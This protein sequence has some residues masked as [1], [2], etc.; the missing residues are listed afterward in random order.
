MESFLTLICEY[1]HQA[2]WIFFLMLLLAGCNL[3]FSED[4]IAIT[5]GIIVATCLPD[6]MLQMW[7]WI[8]AGSCMSAWIA[9]SIGRF[10]G[11]KLYRIKW[12][13]RFASPERLN[14]LHYYY[15]KFGIFT[16]IA[17][18]FFPGGIR[19]GFAMSCGLSKM[20][21]LAFAIR[22]EIAAAIQ[23]TLLFF[24]G[25]TFAKNYE[26]LFNYLKRYN[27]WALGVIGL[28]LISVIFYK[29]YK[30]KND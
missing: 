6:H 15:E 26:L 23:V 8:Y 13:K 11:P 30:K 10:I 29:W 5:G 28:A 1:S 12:F 21:F 4:A 7:I 2:H 24:L 17:I 25:H 27:E 16:F 3:P 19:N 18:R 20:T 22:D 9:Y 14:K